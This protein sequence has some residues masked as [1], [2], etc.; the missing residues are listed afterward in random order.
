MLI[1][2]LFLGSAI[3][4]ISINSL[5]SQTSNNRNELTLSSTF[6][7]KQAVFSIAYAYNWQVGRKKKLELGLGV[8]LTNF[9]GNKINYTT[10][11]ANL[12]R[13]NTIPF[14]TVLS[15]QSYE[16]WDSLEVQRPLIVALNTTANIKYHFSNKLSAG[17]NIDL[18]GVSI[19]RNSSAILTSSGITR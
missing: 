12:S 6:G 18:F 7:E 14:L 17:F 19:G 4:M 8:R 15:G 9:N 10:A 1:K 3:L 13:T 5:K 11:P 2:A 16:N